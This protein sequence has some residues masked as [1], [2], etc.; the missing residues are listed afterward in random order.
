MTAL[1]KN[2][3]ITDFVN[4]VHTQVICPK[5]SAASVNKYYHRNGVGISLTVYQQIVGKRI[6]LKRALPEDYTHLKPEADYTQ[7]C[8]DSFLKLIAN[9][10]VYYEIST[11]QLIHHTWIE[12]FYHD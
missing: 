11:D 6:T 3:P 10:I 9:E 5:D 1:I 7:E 2:I 4:L 12:G 8:I